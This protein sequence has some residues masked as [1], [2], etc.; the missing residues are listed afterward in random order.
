MDIPQ[1]AAGEAIVGN[2]WCCPLCKGALETDAES[3]DC[4]ACGQ[5]YPVIGGVPDFRIDALCPFDLAAD[6]RQVA[7][8]VQDID[9]LDTAG[10]V[11]LIFARRPDWSPIRPEA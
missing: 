11:R 2:I 3:V 7:A 5:R 4:R 9:G 6:R 10:A 8:F 1:N